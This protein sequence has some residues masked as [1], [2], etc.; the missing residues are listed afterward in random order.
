MQLI[1]WVI[2]S[3][4]RNDKFFLIPKDLRELDFWTIYCPESHYDKDR[5]LL[6]LTVKSKTY[7]FCKQEMN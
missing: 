7:Y 2:S 3:D 6:I 4:C 1:D 5:E